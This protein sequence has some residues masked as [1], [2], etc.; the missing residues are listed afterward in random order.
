MF[1]CYG[2]S[3]NVTLRWTME[4]FGFLF[5]EPSPEQH[6]SAVSHVYVKPRQGFHT[7]GIGN[8]YVL[9]AGCTTW[10]EFERELDRLQRELDEIRREAQL[11]FADSNGKRYGDDS[12][13]FRLLR[14]KR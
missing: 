7:R 4:S 14:G 3:H 2:H 1:V 13:A 9:T 10:Q 11:R 5:V 6:L 12:R 8:R